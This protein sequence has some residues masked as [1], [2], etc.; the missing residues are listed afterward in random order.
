M[1]V[2]LVRAD[3]VK[4]NRGGMYEVGFRPCTIEIVRQLC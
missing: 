2:G 1:V 4:Q 3:K